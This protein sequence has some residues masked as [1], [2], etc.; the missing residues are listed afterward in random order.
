[1]G[2]RVPEVRRP[3]TKL[4]YSY[5]MS[6]GDGTALYAIFTQDSETSSTRDMPVTLLE[7]RGPKPRADLKVSNISTRKLPAKARHGLML[8]FR[9]RGDIQPRGPREK[10][11]KHQSTVINT[12]PHDNEQTGSSSAVAQQLK[13][14]TDIHEEVG[15]IPGLASRV[16]DPALP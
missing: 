5:Y 14:P 2:E 8:K 9:R 10:N 15:L 13:N 12:V 4:S 11:H 6:T 3:I 16:K 7:K 1:M